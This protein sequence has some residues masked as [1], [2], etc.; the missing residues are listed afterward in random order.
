[1][2]DTPTLNLVP[3]SGVLHTMTFYDNIILGRHSRDF[4]AACREALCVVRN[5]NRNEPKLADH[6]EIDRSLAIRSWL[7][8]NRNEKTSLRTT[9]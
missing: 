6:E 1:M 2:S 9:D 7:N 4:T 3:F 8:R 5:R